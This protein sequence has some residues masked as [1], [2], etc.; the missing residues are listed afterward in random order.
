[1]A[2]AGY[3]GALLVT[4]PPSI[5]LGADYALT[6]SGDHTT[7]NN[8][9][10]NATERY[11]DRASVPV[12]QTS[13]DG[14][15]WIAALAGTTIRSIGGQVVLPAALTGTAQ[16]RLHSGGKYFP[17]ALLANITQWSFDGEMSFEDSTSMSGAIGGGSGSPF[18]TFVPMLLTGLMSVTKFWVPET[19]EGYVADITNG[20]YLLFSGVAGTGNRYEGYGWIKKLGIKTDVSKLTESPLDIQFDGTFYAV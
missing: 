3:Q 14:T 19:S 4:S 1:M 17:Y 9:V 7:Y 16:V 18:K 6:D 10:A 8:P 5:T 15:T 2:I 11:W 13:V 12:V 20:T